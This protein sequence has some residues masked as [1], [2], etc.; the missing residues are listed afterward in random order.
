MRFLN[1][2]EQLPFSVWVRESSSIWAFPTFLVLHTIGM[3]MVAGLS[4]ML[5]LALLGFWPKAP[6]KPLERLYPLMWFGF[7][8]NAVT[9]TAL[10]IAD[11]VT[12]LTNWDFYVKMVFVF[13]GMGVL[14][15]M[16][17]KVFDDPQLDH[18]PG[19][20]ERQ[21]IGLDVADLLVWSDYSGSLAGLCRPGF[22]PQRHHEQVRR[23]VTNQALRSLA[24][25]NSWI[26]TSSVG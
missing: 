20:G 3:A 25:I 9:G 18:G 1:M 14:Y 6:V 11:A 10:L 5:D 12:K 8:I 22:R 15:V 17:K 24:P 7:G 13:V 19:A 26:L 4:T 21:G 16:R 2:L 23:P